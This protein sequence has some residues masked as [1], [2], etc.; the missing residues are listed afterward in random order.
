MDLYTTTTVNF[1]IVVLSVAELAF[2]SSIYDFIVTHELFYAYPKKM[3]LII[4]SQSLTQYG[5]ASLSFIL[6][7]ASIVYNSYRLQ[8][9]T[10]RFFIIMHRT[11]LFGCAV[12]HVISCWMSY[13]TSLKVALFITD[14][15]VY[16]FI[17]AAQWYT[18]RLRVSA[19][20]FAFTSLL[21]LFIFFL[22]MDSDLRRQFTNVDRFTVLNK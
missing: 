13:Q 18:L 1:L 15:E 16:D 21:S 12:L 6:S 5:A 4:P 17:E 14:D 19:V 2:T 7:F 9:I 22:N 20:F 11:V 8:T 10:S 3:L